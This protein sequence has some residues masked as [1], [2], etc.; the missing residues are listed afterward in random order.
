MKKNVLGVSAVLT[1][2]LA[3]GCSKTV[4]LVSTSSPVDNSAYIGAMI[5]ES[6]GFVVGAYGT[7]HYTEDGG[8]TWQD[9][10]NKSACLFSMQAIDENTC[11]ASGYGNTVIQTTDGGKTWT[12]KKA[13]PGMKSKGLSFINT[14]T[15]WDWTKMELY[16]LAGE[17]PAWSTIPRPEGSSV[18]E[19]ACMVGIGEGWLCDAKGDLYFTNDAGNT[20]A[21]KVHLFDKEGDEFIPLTATPHPCTVIYAKDNSVTAVTAGSVGNK[22]ALKIS[23]SNDN[24]ETWSTCPI[25]YIDEKPL[26]LNFTLDGRLAIFNMDAAL[27]MYTLKI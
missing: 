13:L 16:Q 27:S 14:D 17:N 9:G 8:Q 20:W 22:S 7:V 12:H 18:I 1:V 25:S 19:G 4:N 2:F 24:G 10:V 6:K 26:S 11:I 5:N 3:M 21:K 23:Y 15:G